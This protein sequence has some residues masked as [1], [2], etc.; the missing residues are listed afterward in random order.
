MI[1]YVYK[2]FENENVSRKCKGGDD[3]GRISYVKSKSKSKV[4]FYYSAL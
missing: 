4:R 2:T 3:M 1:V